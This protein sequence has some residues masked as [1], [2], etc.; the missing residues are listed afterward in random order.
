MFMTLGTL[1]FSTAAGISSK[2][3]LLQGFA[4]IYRYTASLEC[5]RN[6][7]DN[8]PRKIPKTCK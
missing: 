6:P 2:K 7:L 4:N 1:L 8:I 3:D 5:L